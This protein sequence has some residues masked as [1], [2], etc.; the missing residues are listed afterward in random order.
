MGLLK[1]IFEDVTGKSNRPEIKGNRFE[2]FVSKEIF[3]DKLFDLVEMTRDFDSNSKRFEERS[4]N[5]DFLFRD[6]RT[7]E[8]FWIEAKYR[9]GLF[10]NEKGQDV[11]EICKPWQ[12]TRYKEV[13]K[14]TGKKVYICLG[15]G[16]DPRY[17][18]SVHLIPVKDAFPQLFPS[19]LRET[20]IWADPDITN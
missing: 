13:E 20:R 9:N 16:E 3:I 2:S 11:C 17:P 19:R 10:K 15:I 7:R 5:P 14:S 6:K 8:E 18:K 4:M 1:E 12:L